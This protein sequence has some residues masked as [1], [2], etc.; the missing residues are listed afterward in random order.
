MLAEAWAGVLRST[1]ACFAE[2][3]GSSCRYLAPNWDCWRMWEWEGEG[4]SV[5]GQLGVET[6]AP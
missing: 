5:E 1:E 3:S 2:S 6:L 4:L